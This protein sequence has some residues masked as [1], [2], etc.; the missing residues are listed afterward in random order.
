MQRSKKRRLA[1]VQLAL[2]CGSTAMMLGCGIPRFRSPLCGPETP[3]NYSFNNGKVFW[4]PAVQPIKYQA[5]DMLSADPASSGS[6]VSND[7]ADSKHV[8]NP[9]GSV[10][11]NRTNRDNDQHDSSLVPTPAAAEGTTKPSALSKILKVVSFRRSVP[12]D[13]AADNAAAGGEPSFNEAQSPPL[14][15]GDSGVSNLEVNSDGFV[16]PLSNDAALLVM[17]GMGA[18]PVAISLE[19]SA[20]L[21]HSAFYNDP[22]LLGLIQQAL[23]GNQELRILG[24]EI[25]IASNE[26]Y[27]R[28]GEYRPFVDVGVGAGI[29]KP[30]RYTREGAVEEQ[31]EVAPGKGFPEPLPNFLVGAN[32][33]WEIDIWNKVR[34]A[35]RAA[36]M[37]YLGTREGRNYVVTRLVAEVAE[38][39]YDL[40][41]LD[42]RRQILDKT[43]E[44]QLASREA[45]Q[46]KKDAG[47]GTELAIQRFQAEIEKNQAEIA[48]ILQE[49]VENENRINFLVGRYPHPIDRV[50]VEFIDLNLNTLSAGVPS[51]LL[52]NRADIRQA[53]REVAAAGLDVRVARAR[54]YPS[55]DLTGGV[56]WN[57]FNTGFLF[58]S[59]ESLMYGVAAEL[60]GPLINK[61]AI[62]AAYSSANAVQL[63]SI[64][65]YQQTVLEAHIEVV[66]YITKVENYHRSIESKKQQLRSLEASVDAAT[67]LFQ[68]ARAEYVEVLLAQREL[69]EAKTQV[70][71]IKRQQLTAIVNAYQALGGGAF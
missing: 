48:V 14:P 22:Y 30:S 59:P 4:E 41:A 45:A 49:I 51:Q 55:L 1:G 63:Q 25:R 36:T 3:A 11:L 23:T 56:G 46:A 44:I 8:V 26:A 37:R 7:S 68:N 20:C 34:N 16:Q 6:S 71:E 24:E 28:S 21:P 52:Q 18:D 27:A 40:L 43:I 12:S 15:V 9:G 69:M 61:R 67:K 13:N 57:A 29:D 33:S 65:K 54:F 5:S 31:L 17:D 60:V 35:Q 53:E 38:S 32:I 62:Q 39:Y 47:R 2:V 58:R 70:V 66:N 42:S 10:A 50:N 19:N 64:Y